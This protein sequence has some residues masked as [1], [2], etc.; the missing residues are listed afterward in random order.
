MTERRHHLADPAE[1]LAFER[2]W[3]AHAAAKDDAIRARFGVDAADYY[4]A[5][6]EV[7]DHPDALEHDALLVRRLQRQRAARRR[8]RS[9]RR[10]RDA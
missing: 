3:W 5:L 9:A 7:I 4:L 10:L 2:A 1:V 8:E 6:A